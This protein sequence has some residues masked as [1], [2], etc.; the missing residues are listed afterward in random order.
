VSE[1]CVGGKASLARNT[2]SPSIP[3]NKRKNVSRLRI[4]KKKSSQAQGTGFIELHATSP[5]T[6]FLYDDY[7]V[8]TQKMLNPYRGQVEADKAEVKFTREERK[9]PFSVKPEHATVCQHDQNRELG[10]I[11]YSI[12]HEKRF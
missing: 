10:Q 9:G 11:H 2:S 3:I 4:G 1:A 7:N 5:A 6:R 12:G 8:Q